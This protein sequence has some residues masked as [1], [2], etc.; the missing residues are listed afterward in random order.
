MP[1]TIDNRTTAHM[2]WDQMVEAYPDS[3][4][5]VENPVFDGDYPDILEG[6]V[7]DVISDNDVG[8]YRAEHRDQ[9]VWVRRTTEGDVFGVIDANFSIVTI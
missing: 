5:A 2:T 7:V 3:W 6:D 9:E 8:D 4:V 1:T